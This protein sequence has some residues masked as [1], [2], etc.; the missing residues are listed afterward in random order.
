[1]LSTRNAEHQRV[2]RLYGPNDIG[3]MDL[4]ASETAEKVNG[5][6]ASASMTEANVH[7]IWKRFKVDL[8]AEL[9]LDG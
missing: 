4:S 1:M 3:S 5:D 2:I 6:D 7:Q 9:G 8:H